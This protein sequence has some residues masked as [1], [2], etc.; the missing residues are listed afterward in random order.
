MKNI[1]VKL[2]PLLAI[3]IATPAF[4]GT[5]NDRIDRFNRHISYGENR[6]HVAKYRNQPVKVKVKVIQ[7]QYSSPRGIHQEVRRESLRH[8]KYRGQYQALRHHNN[9]FHR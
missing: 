4:A 2:L 8:R 7:R 5:N 9:Y 6:P 1:L 3:V